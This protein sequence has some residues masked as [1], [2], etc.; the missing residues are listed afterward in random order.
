MMTDS[1]V[2]TDLHRDFVQG[3][4]TLT[5][6]DGVSLSVAA[7][8]VVGLTGAS[9][10]GKSTLLQMAGLLDTA[11]AGDVHIAG[12]TASGASDR[13]RSE[14]RRKH[15]GFVYQFH[16]LMPDFTALENVSIAAQI[17]GIN[18]GEARRAATEMLGDMGLGDRLEHIPAALSGGE[19]QRVAIARALVHRPAV[20]LADEPTGNLD[21]ETSDRVFAVLMDR[22]RA[23]GVAALIATHD[24]A[25]ARRMDRVVRV[26][27]GKLSEPEQ[28]A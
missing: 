28:L 6:L 19:Q 7:G 24:T 27:G 13:V 2:I 23:L 12:E 25:L 16:H 18:A 8:E 4:K 9:G 21:E 15:L 17:A 22:V 5:I 26:S 20:L 10:A 3:S 14:I 11:T 1:L